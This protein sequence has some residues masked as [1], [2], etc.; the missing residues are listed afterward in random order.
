MLNLWSIE[1]SINRPVWPKRLGYHLG[2][3]WFWV[4][5]SLFQY[6]I[7]QPLKI[8]RNVKLMN[9]SEKAR[10]MASTEW[11]LRVISIPHIQEYPHMQNI[12]VTR[13]SVINAFCL[14]ILRMIALGNVTVFQRLWSRVMASLTD[15]KS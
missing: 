8:W 2:I 3:K 9:F 4:R 10:P 14:G 12:S 1:S 13:I 15:A 7:H 5:V 11:Q 6:E